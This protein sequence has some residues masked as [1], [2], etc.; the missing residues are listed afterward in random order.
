M[1]RSEVMRRSHRLRILT[2]VGGACI[3]LAVPIASVGCGFH[4]P[5]QSAPVDSRTDTPPIEIPSDGAIDA[6]SR[7]CPVDFT[8]IGTS[9]YRHVTTVA[10]WEAAR[11]SCRNQTNELTP[12]IHLVVFSNDQER[13]AVRTAFPNSKLWIGLSDRVMTNVWRWVTAEDNGAYPPT[14]GSPWKAGQPNDG[15]SGE[16][17]C[18]VMENSGELDDRS[19]SN[20]TEQ[21]LCECDAFPELASQS[22]PQT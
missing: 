20:D 21:F 22:D 6:S 9:R 10:T 8:S 4:A 11:T 5:A 15:G 13:A 12:S 1:L 16:E 14:T 3:V 7:P 17:D 18:V 19:C 2:V